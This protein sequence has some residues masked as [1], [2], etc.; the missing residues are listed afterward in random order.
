MLLRKR[1][2]DKC[3]QWAAGIGGVVGFVIGLF[4]TSHIVGALG[5][6]AAGAL[7]GLALMAWLLSFVEDYLRFI[8]RE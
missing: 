3:F 5:G 4:Q 1:T 2:S 8:G 7:G 6:A